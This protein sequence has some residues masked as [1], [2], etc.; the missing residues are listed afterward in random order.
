MC[1]VE[2]LP[3]ELPALLGGFLGP[4]GPGPSNTGL[5]FVLATVVE[6]I[7]DVKGL[8]PAMKPRSELDLE[9]GN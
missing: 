8:I 3:L 9:L 1:G 6:R 4:W 5:T 7:V 2:T